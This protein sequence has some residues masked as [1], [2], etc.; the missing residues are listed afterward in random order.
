[1]VRDR[2]GHN[3]EPIGNTIAL[4]NSTITDPH[5]RPFPQ[6]GVP[7]A[8]TLALVLYAQNSD[9]EIRKKFLRNYNI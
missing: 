9:S 3:G 7:N 4:L 2:N 1:M 6:N 8:V 5:D